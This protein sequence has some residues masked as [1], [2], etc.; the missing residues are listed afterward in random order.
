MAEYFTVGHKRL[1]RYTI[2]IVKH[3]VE[4]KEMPLDALSRLGFIDKT[5]A[6]IENMLKNRQDWCFEFLLDIIYHLLNVL[7]EKAK[8]AGGETSAAELY[9]VEQLFENFGACIKLLS[10]EYESSIVDRAS[11]CLIAILQLYAVQSERK[12]KEIF[13]VDEHMKYLLEAL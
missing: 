6:I 1:N 4:S 7:N 10:S 13:F 5:N 11:Q 8:N 9:V 12:T 2:K 3:I